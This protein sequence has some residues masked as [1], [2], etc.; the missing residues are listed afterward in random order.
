MPA[1]KFEDARNE[2][3]YKDRS[4]RAREDLAF[5]YLARDPA[6]DSVEGQSIFRA[7]SD[8]AI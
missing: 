8:R 3:L 6:S 5:K 4:T 7:S 1:R 2:R